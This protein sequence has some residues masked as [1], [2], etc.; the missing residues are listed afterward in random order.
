MCAYKVNLDEY[1]E[2]GELY[3]KPSKRK[4]AKVKKMKP[5]YN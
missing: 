3:L 2:D 4:T 5:N 1:D